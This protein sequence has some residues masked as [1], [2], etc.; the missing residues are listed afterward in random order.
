MRIDSNS[1]PFCYVWATPIMQFQFLQVRD[2]HS[3]IRLTKR[4]QSDNNLNSSGT[5]HSTGDRRL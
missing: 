1:F 4:S 3:L 2:K 5:V